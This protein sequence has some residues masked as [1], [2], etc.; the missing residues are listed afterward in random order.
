MIKLEIWTM[1]AWLPG[2]RKR[3]GKLQ[4]NTT[5]PGVVAQPYNPSTWEVEAGG[6]GVH[7]Q[8]GIYSEVLILNIT[9]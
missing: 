2:L 1:D 8:S 9:Y 5:E 6:L 4:K 7:G 3:G